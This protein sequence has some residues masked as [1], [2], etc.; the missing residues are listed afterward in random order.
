MN[1]WGIIEMRRNV[2]KKQH[3]KPDVKQ[4]QESACAEL[5]C[6]WKQMIKEHRYN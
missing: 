3:A 6:L 4:M 2:L 1:L 5:D